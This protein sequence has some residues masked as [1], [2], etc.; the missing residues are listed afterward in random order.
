MVERHPDL[1]DPSTQETLQATLDK[2]K[3]EAEQREHAEK[4]PMCTRLSRVKEES[5]K[6]GEFIEWLQAEYN[7]HLTLCDYVD[8]EY[9]PA[10]IRMEVLLA[11]YFGIDLKKLEEERRTMLKELQRKAETK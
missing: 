4:Y 7:P 1:G 8:D 11:A 9:L 3:W 5:Q 6:L 10:D 2:L